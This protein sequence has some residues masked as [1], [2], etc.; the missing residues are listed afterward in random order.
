M[1]L[2]IDL[3]IELHGRVHSLGVP[4][5]VARLLEQRA[6]RDVRGVHELVAALLVALARVVLHDPAHD[7]ALRVE[8]S[9]ARPDLLGE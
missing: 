8:D 2:G 9:K 4:L 7:P 1:A 6:F 5:Q 3:C